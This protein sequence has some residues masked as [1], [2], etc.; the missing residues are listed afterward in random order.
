MI[1]KVDKL[2]KKNQNYFYFAFRV[3]VGLMFFQHGAQK[4]FGLFSG[5]QVEL[6][7]LMGL[8]GVIEFT[9]GLLIAFGL[10]VQIAALIGIIDMLG[11]LFIAHFPRG[12]N[13]LLNGGELALLY[14][15]SF[16]VLAIYGARSWN[17]GSYLNK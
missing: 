6:F 13:P 11:A 17:L 4:L 2:F 14:L 15:L 1:K 12:W 7:S 16:F 10:F 9:A 3:L 8:A 5:N